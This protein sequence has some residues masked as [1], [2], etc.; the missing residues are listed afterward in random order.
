MPDKQFFPGVIFPVSD[1][2]V[3]P[4]IIPTGKIDK[5]AIVS[6]NVDSGT[7]SINLKIDIMDSMLSK[8]L[9]NYD[10]ATFNAKRTYFPF[11]DIVNNMLSLDRFEFN[12]EPTTGTETGVKFTVTAFIPGGKVGGAG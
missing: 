9:F 10:E 1:T 4:I 8:K 11:S 12:L 6:A 2:S 3:T 5:R 7:I